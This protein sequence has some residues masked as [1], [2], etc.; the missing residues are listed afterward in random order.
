MKRVATEILGDLTSVQRDGDFSRRMEGFRAVYEKSDRILSNT[1]VRVDFL[2]KTSQIP[3]PAWTDGKTITIN[4]PM[5]SKD[6][7]NEPMSVWIRQTK[8]L[9]LHELCHV[10]Y[11][12]RQSSDLMKWVRDAP[13]RPDV[14]RI[15]SLIKTCWNILEDQRIET[16][17]VAKF[18]PA[19]PY[20]E[21]MVMKWLLGREDQWDNGHLM[22]HGRRYL[23]ADLAKTLRDRFEGVYGEEIAE[24]GRRIIDGYLRLVFPIDTN[25]AKQFVTDFA[26][27]MYQMSPKVIPEP[28]S[29][30]DD[31]IREGGSPSVE[32]QKEAQKQIDEVQPRERNEDEEDDE[33]PGQT[34]GEEGDEDEGVA[35][36]A[37][38]DE[39]DD[40]SEGEGAEGKGSGE[41][42]GEASES[43][44]ADGMNGEGAGA[45]DPNAPMPTHKDMRKA[46]K[47]AED[48]LHE[49]GQFKAEVDRTAKAVQ[50][51][52]R[53][54]E[55]VAQ[56]AYTKASLVKVPAEVRKASTKMHEVLREIK[57]ELEETHRN[58]QVSGQIDPKRYLARQPWDVDFFRS[59]DPGELEET[60]I[61]CVILVDQSGSMGGSMDKVSG[62]LW[63]AKKA[64][65][66]L[67]ARVTVLGFADRCYM[68]Y[69]PEDKGDKTEMRVFGCHGGTR[70][71]ETLTEA[72]KV[73]SQSKRKIKLMLTLTDGE[74]FDHAVDV[75]KSDMLV[76]AING[77]EVTTQLQYLGSGRGRAIESHH[78]QSSIIINDPK[79]L[80][81][82]AVQMVEKSMQRHVHWQE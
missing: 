40:E 72:Y 54:N 12:P 61:E 36:S 56:G 53:D 37:G 25:K 15:S 44:E 73:F 70:P 1:D 3:A 52:I 67:D 65:E 62:A 24:E 78:H 76:K 9:N 43:D 74:W 59:Y 30:E 68:L 17:F 7:H 11:T 8:A 64:L 39:G 47:E 2:S 35:G 20:F 31:V 50:D 46:F 69:G 66:D 18:R 13:N 80:A 32:R 21:S 41:E 48:E 22:I 51:A 29:G 4:G 5:L 42:Q 19:G 81:E 28:A 57:V 58:R 63:A 38:A 23:P 14:S 6:L 79:A 33:G 77:L 71:K 82:A 60:D 34:E 26:K 55:I 16:M 45:G 49:D 27:L 10:M 75:G